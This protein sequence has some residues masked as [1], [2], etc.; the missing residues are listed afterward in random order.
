LPDGVSWAGVAGGGILC[1]IGFTMALFIAGLALEGP[2]LAAAKVGI[3]AGSAL[4]AAAGMLVLFSGAQNS[5]SATTG[6]ER[7]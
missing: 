2:A 7:G 4:A 3:L 6:V 5:P 1:G